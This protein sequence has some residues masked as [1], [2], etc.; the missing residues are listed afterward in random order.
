MCHG[1]GNR[2]LSVFESNCRKLPYA[3]SRLSDTNVQMSFIGRSEY[4]ACRF[5]RVRQREVRRG[6][7][8]TRWRGCRGHRRGCL[9]RAG[10][11]ITVAPSGTSRVTTAPA[12]TVASL[13]IVTPPRTVALLPIAAPDLTT[14]L[15]RSQSF[16]WEL[17][18]EGLLSLTNMT[19]CPT[20]T[21]SSR[22]TPSQMKVWDET[23]QFRPIRTPDCSSTNVPII[24]PSPI[25]HSYA[26]TQF[27]IRTPSPTF[28]FRRT[29]R[30]SLTLRVFI[31][32]P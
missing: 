21:S 18:P 13:P 14:T 26:L 6:R 7:R 11:P 15:L 9:Y 5:T 30:E 31:R 4:V 27:Q 1:E 25:S 24:D 16:Q 17:R 22:V 23:W 2:P 32:R 19:P 29:W 28:T 20:K 8:Q 12:P 3:K 10:T